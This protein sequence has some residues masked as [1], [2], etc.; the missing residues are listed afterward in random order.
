MTKIILTLSILSCLSMNAQSEETADA[1]QGP[2]KKLMDACK[3]ADYARG[4]H[5]LKKGLYKDC[6]IPLLSDTPQAVPGV[7]I[8]TDIIAACK[9]IKD[10]KQKT[11]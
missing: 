9:K 10:A 3:A 1:K 7:T 8:S 11:K 4:D 6:M 5:N 2:C